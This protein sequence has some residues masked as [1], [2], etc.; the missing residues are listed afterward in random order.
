MI[1]HLYFK[2]GKTEAQIASQFGITCGTVNYYKN[3]QK[4]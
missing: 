2:L 1:R 3:R 4:R